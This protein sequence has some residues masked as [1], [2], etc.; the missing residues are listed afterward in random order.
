MNNTNEHDVDDNS[1]ILLEEFLKITDPVTGD[2]I[3][4]GRA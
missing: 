2:V 1:G 4:E 3:Y